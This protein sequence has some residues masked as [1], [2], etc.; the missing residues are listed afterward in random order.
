MKHKEYVEEVKRLFALPPRENQP[1]QKFSRGA[2]VKVCR[3]MPS[4]MSHFQSGFE[5]IVEYTY[6][7]K[8]G[9]TDVKSYSLIMLK[10]NVP[11][12]AI[13]WYEENQL[14]L[15]SNDIKDGL[16]IIK[17][18]IRFISQRETNT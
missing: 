11:V 10:N 8:Y 12:N 15:I 3:I 4:Y 13:A 14:T 6:A 1:G 9:G 5:A 16:K 17:E 2:R 18:Y 7:Q